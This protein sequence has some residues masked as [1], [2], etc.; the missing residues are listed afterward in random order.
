VKI[1]A[2]QLIYYVAAKTWSGARSVGPSQ[3]KQKS[4]TVEANIK[5]PIKINDYIL[6][7]LNS[8]KISQYSKFWE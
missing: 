7:L 1:I 6:S 2:V 5:N 4:C 8:L 3:Q